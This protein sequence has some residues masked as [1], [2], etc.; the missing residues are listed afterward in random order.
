MHVRKPA[1]LM[2][3]RLLL[4]TC[5]LFYFTISQAQIIN[6]IAGGPGD[7]GPALNTPLPSALDIPIGIAIDASGNL[8][9][10]SKQNSRI[11][12]VNASTGIIS[13]V[14][15]NGISGFGGD[16]GLATD[17]NL[18]EP[19]GIA[20]DAL[21]NLYIADSHNNR[22]RKVD[23]NTS[24]IS[25][26]AGDG[27]YSFGGDGGLATN[28]SI[29]APLGI[30]VDAFG[31]LY[32]A[33]TDNNRIRKVNANTGIIST[34]AG[35][36]STGGLGDGGLATNARLSTPSSVAFDASGNV[37]IADKG[38]ER[39]R[40]V[41]TTTGII[42][43]VAGSGFNIGDGGLA[44]V[45]NLYFPTCV[46]FD[47]SGNL[48]IA[49]YWNH[50]IR[51]V[52]TSTGIISTVAGNGNQ[53]FGGDGGLATAANLN[54][55]TG[56]ALDSTGN[57]YIADQ[58]NRI[59]KVNPV[60]GIIN[61]IAGNGF[62]TYGGD[63]GIANIAS[64]NDPYD[65]AIDSLGNLYISDFGNN[66]IRKVS[67]GT[68]IITTIAGDG[69]NAY[70]GDGGAATAA[71]LNGPKGM[72]ID[73][74]GNIY[75]ADESNHRIR[76]VIASTGIITTVAGNGT[77]NSGGDGGAATAA[78]LEYP[79]DVALDA[80]G[81]L[82]IAF[83]QTSRIRK[84]NV[85]TGI[86]STVAGGGFGGDGGLA[87]NASLNV[88]TGVTVDAS[89][90]FYIADQGDHRIRKVNASTGIISTVAGNG[91]Q[92]FTGDG[93]LA[94]S[95]KLSQPSAI[96][97]DKSGNLYIADI[98]NYRI[99]KVN[100]N[101]GFI[102]TVA[103]N[104]TPSFG[105]DGGA[106]TAA[107]FYYPSNITIDTSGSF[108]IPDYFNDRI[109]K[110]SSVILNNTI[111]SSQ[112]I[113]LGSLPDSI[114]GSV[115]N[116]SSFGYT[117]SWIKS[118][119]SNSIGFTSIASSNF[120][121]YKPSA[122]TQS[123]WFKRVVISGNLKDTSAAVLISVS[124]PITNNSIVSSSQTICSGS[125]PST[126]TTSE[127]GGGD[128]SNYN[129][130]WLVSTTN[131][132]SGYSAISSSNVQNYLPT[133]L[134]QN[135]WFKRV[136]SSGVCGSDTS[137]AYLIS[138]TP[139]PSVGFNSNAANQCL[140][141]NSYSF[142]DTSKISS[143]TIISRLWTL[144]NGDTTSIINPIKVFSNAGTYNIKLLTISDN[145]CKDSLTKTVIVYPNT[146]IGFKINNSIQCVNNSYFFTD[147]STISSG[148]FTRLWNFGDSS[149][150]ASSPFTKTYSNT[151]TYQVLLVTTSNFGCKDSITKTVTVNPKPTAG[152]AINIDNQCLKTNSY[153]F[154]D[155]SK[156]ASGAFSRLWTLGNGDTTSIINP[157]KV[158]SDVGA[159]SIKLLA[160]SDNGCKDSLT[161]SVVV[162]PNTNIGFKINNATQCLNGNSFLY[163]DTSN[164]SSG[165]YTRVWNFGDAPSTATTSPFTKN[166]ATANTYQVKLMATTNN[167]CK[168]SIAKT[169]MVN[170]KPDVYFMNTNASQCLKGNLFS[171]PDSSFI[172]S[173]SISRTW[174]LGDG[175][176]DK[177][178]VAN[179]SYTQAQTYQVKLVVTSNDAC[180]DSMMSNVTVN[181][182][183][184]SVATALN[185]TSICQGK[186]TNIKANTGIGFTYQWLNSNVVINNAKDSIINVSNQGNYSV[187]TSNT[188]GC[189]DS[190]NA[191]AILVN[192]IPKP[193]FTINNPSQ[194][195]N[196]N[197]FTY[198]DTS[199][200]ALRLWTLANG[201]VD[202][203]KVITNSITSA[204]TYNIKLRVVS[205]KL[206]VD[207]ISKSITVIQN[208]SI[209]AIQGATN[210]GMSAPYAYSIAS[211]ANH[212]YLWSAT[213]GNIISG[214]GTNSVQVQ[215]LSAGA[216]KIKVQ[217]SNN[218]NCSS[219]DSSMVSISNVGIHELQSLSQL[220]LYPNPNNGDFKLKIRSTK[221]SET[222]I[223]LLNMLGQEVWT[224]TKTII[225]GTQEMDLSTNL[226]AGVY[227]LRLNNVDGQVQKSVVVR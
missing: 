2:I 144:G 5:T 141:T 181:P 122:L 36:I 199:S 225:V 11:R 1:K 51:K 116:G 140:I 162:Y 46:T 165:T 74:L 71:S 63:G 192:P 161:K 31:N 187:I 57:L 214:Q 220:E 123:T 120:L 110:V 151:N 4:I 136:V 138:V 99:R 126:I 134:T 155:T 142:V 21:G 213:N 152:F 186:T 73:G 61:T 96:S 119:T 30:T 22:I 200:T 39:I 56:V 17:A 18:Y 64:L 156:I 29:Y 159:Y 121:N 154:A 79:C 45:A 85:S 12:K 6:T 41:T 65:T 102:S 98:G 72:A 77:T 196:G 114:I 222:R 183:P 53:G 129:Y 44:T 49:D 87:T 8:Y 70:G 130:T 191:I 127:P 188:F 112:N 94:I 177:N 125:T 150:S 167:G 218:Q 208:P 172:V 40:K 91:T 132:T 89:G 139:K 157:S 163:T 131:A 205:D 182:Q 184:N 207:S 197:S 78:N 164:L 108:Y 179:K 62:T 145:G 174:Y 75:F 100:A 59:R 224:D 170:P 133:A 180:K 86:I 10:A 33:D 34:V 26:V 48:Y 58:N 80:S 88:P 128:G 81:N 153:S 111:N 13:T 66:R 9:I 117:Y 101:T 20:L 76:K 212:I 84:V 15:G 113:C 203:N 149:T 195:L 198:S 178:L 16:G 160:T 38:N 147:T 19:S 175:S 68:N 103:G 90:N 137:T 124:N 35:G 67:A 60:T 109:R 227:I 32:I 146:T 52:T 176:T 171:F 189:S 14:A 7:G 204:G 105:G 190:S 115:P 118:T 92:G 107:S 148:T 3:K 185:S 193:G 226:A 202:T 135:T 93:G 210:V 23:A 206:C 219:T 223:S 106:A 166:Y 143:G 209:G 28:A 50:R 215:W 221:A 43:T 69:N 216:G 47:A 217:L 27:S 83:K 24:I 194:C 54:F 97:I 201:N 211:Q 25:T 82:F 37:Y 55:P 95:A 158:F 169:V 168:D 42:S 173:G 104:G